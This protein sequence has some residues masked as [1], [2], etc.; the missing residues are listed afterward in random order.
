MANI[1]VKKKYTIWQ[2]LREGGFYRVFNCPEYPN[3]WGEEKKLT[4]KHNLVTKIQVNIVKE[5]AHLGS[6]QFDNFD[7]AVIAWA[8][9]YGEN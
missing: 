3:M 2:T 7:E 4:Y 1:P 8:K 9:V 6:Y 5:N